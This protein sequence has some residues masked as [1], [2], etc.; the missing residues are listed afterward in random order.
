[1]I[2]V[3]DVDHPGRQCWTFDVG[4]DKK[5]GILGFLSIH[6]SSLFFLALIIGVPTL[7]FPFLQPDFFF[8][9]CLQ[10]KTTLSPLLPF[11]ITSWL[12]GPMMAGSLFSS[13][14]LQMAKK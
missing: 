4:R 2:K 7:F 3:F 1:M 12:L 11:A 8:P 13:T 6:Y 14:T 5:K 10:G 9:T